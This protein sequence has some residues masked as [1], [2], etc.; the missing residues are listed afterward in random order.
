MEIEGWQCYSLNHDSKS[1]DA[2][3]LLIE[4]GPK[5]M[6][7]L[8]RVTKGHYTCVVI[9]FELNKMFIKAADMTQAVVL[10]SDMEYSRISNILAAQNIDST[11]SELELTLCLEN[12]IEAISNATEDFDNRGLFSTHYLKRRIFDDAPDVDVL[13]LRQAGNDVNKLLKILDWK[14]ESSDKQVIITIQDNFS[15]RQSMA[16]VAPSYTAVSRLSKHKWVILTNGKKWRLYTNRVSASSTNYFEINLNDSDSV[17]KYLGA[18]FTRNNF[19]GNSPR[20]DL[21]FDQGKEFARQL[22][23][24]LASRI[25]SQNGI[26]LNLAKGILNHDMKTVFD[27]YELKSAK[28]VALRI[29][30]R[31]WFV[32]YAESRNLLPVSNKKYADMSLRHLRNELDKYELDAKDYSCWEYLLDLFDGIRHGRPEKNL[33]QYNGKLFKFDEQLDGRKIQNRW[34]VPAIRDILE[35]DGDVIDYASLSVR[36]L[37]SILEN[38]MEYTIQQATKNVM[39]LVKGGKITEVKTT[40]ES[41]YSYKKNDLYLVSK[42]EIEVRKSTASYYTPDEIVT[43]LVNRGLEPILEDKS[44]KI[45]DDIKL[46]KKNPSPENHQRC[47]ERLLDIQVLDPTMGSG[48][49]LVE[50]LNHLTLWATEVSPETSQTSTA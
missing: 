39:L 22:E 25:M 4:S 42:G 32:A 37:G 30:Y 48:H 34:I 31:V 9:S 49:F 10:D 47:I 33:P 14:K 1:R 6:A 7:D 2:P 5:N 13:A 40:H 8:K 3:I 24:D 21:F 15:I 11:K 36:H 43:F 29:I 45:A 12:A 50:A 23:E 35:R 41:T 17:L 26:L 44:A 27:R 19:V 16:D 18:I 28:N 46:Y 20:I 38:V